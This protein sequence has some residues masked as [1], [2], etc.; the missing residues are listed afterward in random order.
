MVILT[1][2]LVGARLNQLRRSGEE[3]ALLDALSYLSPISFKSAIL[4]P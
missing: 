3:M 1:A 2:F 4:A